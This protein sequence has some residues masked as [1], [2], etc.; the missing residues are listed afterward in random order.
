M[1]VQAACLA[2]AD[3]HES[4]VTRFSF[5]AAASVT[6]PRNRWRRSWSMPSCTQCTEKLNSRFPMSSWCRRRRKDSPRNARFE[7][8]RLLPLGYVPT[9]RMSEDVEFEA[10]V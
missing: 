2:S 6:T 7:P 8:A 5:A 4:M 1:L 10:I 3:R 9:G